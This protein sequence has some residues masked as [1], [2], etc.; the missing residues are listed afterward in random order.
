MVKVS[1][2]RVN[3]ERV[4]VFIVYEFFSF[5]PQIRSQVRK[6]KVVG[7]TKPVQWFYHEKNGRRFL[8]SKKISAVCV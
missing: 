7:V 3:L 2:E 1:I 4:L 5:S 6:Q 8:Y